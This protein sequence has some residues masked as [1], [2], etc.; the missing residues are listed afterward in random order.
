MML[1]LGLVGILVLAI[2]GFAYVACSV[3]A[4]SEAYRIEQEEIMASASPLNND[5]GCEI[6]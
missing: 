2:G 6:G 4:L 5:K 3:V 1:V